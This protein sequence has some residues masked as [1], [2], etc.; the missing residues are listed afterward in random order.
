MD[1]KKIAEEVIALVKNTGEEIM[2]LRRNITSEDVEVKGKN[3]FVTR[4]DK[5]SEEKL[6]SGLKQILPESGFVAEEGTSD[7]KGEVYNWYIDPIDG[8]TNFMHGAPPFSIS[9]ALREGDEFVI[10]VVLELFSQEC[11]YSWKGAEVFVNS[12]PIKGSK[13]KT[14]ADSL[15]ATGFPYTNFGRMEKFLKTLTYFMENSHGLRRLGSAA[16]DLCYVAAGRYDGF[17]EYGLSPWDVA[18]GAFL[19]QQNGGSVTDFK[20]GDNYIFGKEL[21]AGN[22]FN[23]AE[24]QKVVGELM[25]DA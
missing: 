1:Y 21:V 25:N 9:V 18:A 2:E 16:I 15:I 13:V 8:T 17:Y 19:V 3:N 24:L 7:E 22:A 12:T 23:S 4:F 6:V 20:G 10:G 5:L 11:F 14:V